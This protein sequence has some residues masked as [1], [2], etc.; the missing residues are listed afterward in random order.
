M[1]KKK[2]S[3]LRL[4]IQVLFF[5]LVALISINHTLVES[6]KPAI[7][8]L[9]AASLHALCPFGGVVS[10]YQVVA[11]GTMVK[12]IH[13][14]AFILMGLGFLA[15][16]LFGPAFCGWL[17]PMGSLQEWIGKLGKKLFRKRYN[18][19]VPPRID[20]LLRYLRYL[21]LVW[22]IYM[23]AVTGTLIFADYDP[24]YALFNLW[25]GEV[26]L[27]GIII[28]AA[29]LVLSLFMERPFCKYAC[30]YGALLGIFNLFR[31]FPLRRVAVTCI[32]CKACDRVC[33]MNI[34]VSTA[35]K[36]KNHQCITCMKCTS[37]QVC[38]VAETV[39]LG[40]LSKKEGTV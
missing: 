16:L 17:C 15:A 22:V 12:K 28:L 2:R 14:S 21:V 20:N 8:I 6:G 29:V 10:V 1:A 26:A 18:H 3:S 19:L 11:S 5:L 23:T 4:I 24:Y 7:P 40:K 34:T 33:P 13:E 38:P 30:P 32:D 31:L 27:S 35:G 9:S 36:V 39:V 25:T 37:D